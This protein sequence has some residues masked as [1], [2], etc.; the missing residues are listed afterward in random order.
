MDDNTRDEGF[1]LIELLAVMLIIG[2][3]AA[4]A[5]PTF[6]SQRQRSYGA[7][8]ESD[9]H[10]AVIAE[11]AYSA[12]HPGYTTAV[13]DLA[14]EGYRATRDVTPVHVKLVGG[15]FVACVK[16]VAMSEWLVYDGAN[17]S[18]TTSASDCA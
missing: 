13:D 18:T 2:A 16:H 3:L 17:G 8:M 12:G 7:A 4:I 15:T 9:L 11:N 6:V 14:D 1:T 10:S 5:I